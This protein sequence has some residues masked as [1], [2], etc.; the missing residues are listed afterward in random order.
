[1]ETLTEGISNSRFPTLGFSH[2]STRDV[3]KVTHLSTIAHVDRESGCAR[4][5]ALCALVL[6]FEARPPVPLFR[7][8]LYS[9]HVCGGQGQALHRANTMACRRW[10]SFVVNIC[11][12]YYFIQWLA[13]RK[14]CGLRMRSGRSQRRT[15]SH[16]TLTQLCHA[17]RR[18]CCDQ[19][20]GSRP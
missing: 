13:F 20:T 18:A 17:H 2:I 5:S 19:A 15:H 11:I 14:T 9:I 7:H 4:A 10:C 3:K 6:V 8:V 16:Y 1:M 12:P